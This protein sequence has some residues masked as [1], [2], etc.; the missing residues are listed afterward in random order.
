MFSAR[1]TPGVPV[2]ACEPL[3][4][5]SLR[6]SAAAASGIGSIASLRFDQGINACLIGEEGA[7]ARLGPDEWLILAPAEKAPMLT[8][9]IE[10]ALSGE[11]H[12][13]VDIGHRNVGFT[14]AGPFAREILNGGC[15]LD[16][17]DS[18]FPARCA[19][20][21][22][23]GKAEFVLMRPGPEREY[24]VEC[25]RSFAPYIFD[26]LLEVA[27]EFAAENPST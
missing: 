26:F 8:H 6:L 4:R 12:S 22:V 15:P 20:R 3:A 19:T 9:A 13:L 21:T 14:V 25:W 7:T 18:A 1:H 10:S 27:S 17:S 24:H 23:F 2:A 11:I 5:F 16:L